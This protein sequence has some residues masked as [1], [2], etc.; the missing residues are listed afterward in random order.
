MNI[1][2]IHR[3][4]IEDRFDPLYYKDKPNFTN[5]IKLSKIA[6]VSGGKR[7][8]LGMSYTKEQTNYLYLRVAD[9][10]D[11]DVAYSSL[12]HIDSDV[13]NI[14]K[15]YE[16]S[17]DDIALS[18]AGTIGK[19]VCLKNIPT[20]NRVILTENCAKIQ[21][22]NNSILPLYLTLLFKSS[23]VQ[24]QIELNCIQTT[25]PKIG[26]DRIRNLSL[27]HIPT[28]KE[29][30]V[31]INLYI[32]AQNQRKKNLTEAQGFI[33]NSDKYLLNEIGITLPQK[34]NSLKNRIFTTSFRNVI[35]NRIDP[36]ANSPILESLRS[37]LSN[38]SFTYL[39]NVVTETKAIETEINP[40]DIYVGLENIESNTGKYIPTETKDS[41]SSAL[42]FKKGQ[43]LFPKLRPYLNKVYLAEFDG[44]CSTEFHVFDAKNIDVHFLYYCLLSK[45]TLAQTSNLMTGNTLPRLQSSDIAHI[46]I[47]NPPIEKQKEIAKHI[48][49]IRNQAKQL[50]TDAETKYKQAMQKIEQM[51]MENN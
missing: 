25:I 13:F 3:S 37:N 14:L 15:R 45:I 27:P 11:N 17:E 32:N 10:L 51:I 24:K 8:P 47:P 21:I 34:D 23:I 31:V 26:L 43:I 44:L 6:M 19:V 9:M 5:F 42:R 22:T 28:Q 35:G 1:F 20:T 18:I 41:I 7:I 36:L 49:N 39:K 4:K 33:D 38:S 2:Q 50:E 12:N 29:Q 30:M 48:Q 40:T 16:I 46:L